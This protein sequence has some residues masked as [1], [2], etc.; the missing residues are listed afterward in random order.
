MHHNELP[1]S[2]EVGTYKLEKTAKLNIYYN[3]NF[4][5][6]SRKKPFSG[7]LLIQYSMYV[8]VVSV[9]YIF[10]AALAV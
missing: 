6:Y 1:T 4:M 3:I 9:L 5:F 7:S 10:Q 2:L 8:S